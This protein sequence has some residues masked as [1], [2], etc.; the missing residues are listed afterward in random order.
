VLDQTKTTGPGKPV[1]L[2]T[3]VVDPS[4]WIVE[5]MWLHQ[6]WLTWTSTKFNFERSYLLPLPSVDL[7]GTRP[8]PARY[9]DALCMTRQ[10]F[11]EL[12]R[13]EPTLGVDGRLTWKLT[14]DPLL[15]VGAQVVWSEHSERGDLPT[16][17]SHLGFAKEDRDCLGR[18]RPEGSDDYIRHMEVTVRR[19]QRA[20][21]QAVRSG[22]GRGDVVCESVAIAE[23]MTRLTDRGFSAEA[24]VQVGSTFDLPATPLPGLPPIVTEQNKDQEEADGRAQ[25]EADAASQA[26][27]WKWRMQVPLRGPGD[28][29]FERHHAP[30]STPLADPEQNE[31]NAG[32][33]AAGEVLVTTPPGSPSPSAEPLG[34]GLGGEYVVSISGRTRFRRLHAVGQ[35][36]RVPGK[37]Y[38]EW[39]P[40]A[41][42][43]PDR[44][45]AICKDCWPEWR[46]VQALA[47]CQEADRVAVREDGVSSSD[48]ESSSS[49]SS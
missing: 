49:Q 45:D 1:R 13:P 34:A 22:L 43:R 25:A 31:G 24:V 44:Y 30:A 10:I 21:A 5:P 26:E 28:P 9:F 29:V 42:L 15:P 38:R 8:E 46:Q 17:T 36:W 40:L 12:K 48:E 4:C 35:C 33:G 20:V 47:K 18:W 11:A 27:Y 2:L 32:A 41:D 16:W 7:A 3:A 19:V 6:G 39:A 14:A 23:L 37:D